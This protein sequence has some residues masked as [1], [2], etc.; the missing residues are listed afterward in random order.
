VAP[1]SSSKYVY[2]HIQVVGK[3]P[4]TCLQEIFS[5]K[6]Q[7]ATYRAMCGDEASKQAHALLYI[8]TQLR[9]VK[10]MELGVLVLIG[11]CG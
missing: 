9:I 1:A 2:V 3:N 5:K 7:C 4:Y 10:P 8:Q 11:S 6:E